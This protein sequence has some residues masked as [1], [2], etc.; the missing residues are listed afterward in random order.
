MDVSHL[1]PKL[2]KLKEA[3]E[4]LLRAAGWSPNGGRWMSNSGMVLLTRDDAIQAIKGYIAT[5]KQKFT[6]DMVG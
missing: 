5:A 3:E 6:R 1:E 4:A 2:K